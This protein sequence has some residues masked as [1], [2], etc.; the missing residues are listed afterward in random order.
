MHGMMFGERVVEIVGSAVF[1]D[2]ANN[3]RGELQF[4]ANNGLFKKSHGDDIKGQIIDTKAGHKHA[5]AK[6][7]GSW[8]T[9][10]HFNE[11]PYWDVETEPMF[12]HTPVADALP[13]DVRFREDV[14]ALKVGSLVSSSCQCRQSD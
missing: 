9:H 5:I 10:L 13:S 2:R 12:E 8:L 4:D 11:K 1:E 14:I 3:L 6:A 7:H